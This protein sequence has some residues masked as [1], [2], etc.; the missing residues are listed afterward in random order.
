MRKIN[1]L[2]IICF[3]TNR[4]IYTKYVALIILLINIFKKRKGNIMVLHSHL[5]FIQ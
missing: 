4:Y 1:V 3:N 2:L 5:H